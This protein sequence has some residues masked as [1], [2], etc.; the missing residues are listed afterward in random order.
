ML[1]I[2]VNNRLPTVYRVCKA[3]PTIAPSARNMSLFPR[4]VANEFAPMFR[5]LD[6]YAA[7]SAGRSSNGFS[8]AL[9][10]WQPRFDVK[11][12]KEGYELQGELP[13]VDQEN[14]SIEFTDANTLSIKGRTER[15]REQ[16]TRPGAVTEGETEK[17]ST[18]ESDVSSGYQKVSVEDEGASV[19]DTTTTSAAN[20]EATTP[21]ETPKEGSV[22]ET[23]T[24]EVAQPTQRWSSRY[25]VSERS[26]GEFARTFSFPNRVDQDHVKA[27][28]KNGILSIVVPK[29][30]A[31]ENRRI[32]IE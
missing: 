2:R 23:Q 12:S 8:N 16:G 4:F 31:P 7:H 5:L 15:H 10:S 28:L 17:Q 19:A 21:A 20:A 29:A 6:E 30:A 26:V 14:I 25:W 13:G 27:S 22:A 18:A 24:Q 1:S 32:N 3:T 9:H 11:E